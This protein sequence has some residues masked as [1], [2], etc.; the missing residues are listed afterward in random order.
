MFGGGFLFVWGSW[1][2]WL[3]ITP[4]SD[5]GPSSAVTGGSVVQLLDGGLQNNAGG[6]VLPR[7]ASG[8]RVSVGFGRIKI[9]ES[10]I[11]VW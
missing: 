3:L 5:P 9:R 8:V 11:Y 1:D 10:V 2:A 4:I 6:G 7:S